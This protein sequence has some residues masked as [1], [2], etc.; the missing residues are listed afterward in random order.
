MVRQLWKHLEM[1]TIQLKGFANNSYQEPI[2]ETLIRDINDLKEEDTLWFL[3]KMKE[4]QRI[5]TMGQREV[6]VPMIL[7]TLDTKETIET[8]GLLDSR[9]TT[10][11]I[12]QELVD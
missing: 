5:K 10:T 11:S 3:R 6:N 9:C 2:D 8:E 12:S 7:K 1:G 4:P